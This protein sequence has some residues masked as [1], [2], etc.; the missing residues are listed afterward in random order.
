[1]VGTLYNFFVMDSMVLV[2][3]EMMLDGQTLQPCQENL[4]EFPD[5]FSVFGESGLACSTPWFLLTLGSIPGC[6]LGSRQMGTRLCQG[7]MEIRSHILLIEF[8][9]KNCLSGIE[10]KSKNT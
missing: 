7:Q 3:W 5:G 4:V 9:V 2:L 8:N 10:L 6:P 1:M